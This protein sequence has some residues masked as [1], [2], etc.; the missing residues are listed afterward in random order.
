MALGT[1][2]MQRR[3]A[4]HILRIQRTLALLQQQLNERHGAHCCGAVDGVLTPLIL[5]SC[6]GLGGEEFADDGDVFLGGCE[7]EGCLFVLRG[8]GG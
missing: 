5:Y 8:S 1:R 6:G 4:L 7:V 2:M 3:Q